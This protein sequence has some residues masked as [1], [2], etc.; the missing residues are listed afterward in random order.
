MASSQPSPSGRTA[1]T[2]NLPAPVRRF[3]RT[4]TGSAAILLGAT[5]GALFWVNL[6]GSSYARLWHTELSIHLGASG[7]SQDLRAWVDQG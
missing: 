3:L 4:E 1:W 6:G 7:V 5:L 2:R